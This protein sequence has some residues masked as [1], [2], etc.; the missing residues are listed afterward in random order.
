MNDWIVAYD[1]FVELTKGLVKERGP[2]KVVLVTDAGLP[3]YDE[4]PA[5][6]NLISV[7]LKN[8]IS[9]A[10]V[11]VMCQDAPAAVIGKI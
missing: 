3:S 6:R 4:V 7:L 9:E 1:Y 5:L 11:K 10:D 2:E 8:G